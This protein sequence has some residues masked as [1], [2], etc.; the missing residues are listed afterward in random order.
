MS[1][2]QALLKKWSDDPDHFDFNGA[3]T[4]LWDYLTK[5]T[6]VLEK[7]TL[8]S[9][10]D[11]PLGRDVWQ[12]N[13]ER[14]L[15][16]TSHERQRCTTCQRVMTRR[17]PNGRCTGHNCRGVNVREKPDPN[18]YD[19]WLM[20]RPFVMVSAEEHTAQVPGEERNRIEQ[21]FKSKHGKTNCLV[22]TPTLEMGV[23]IGLLDMALMRNVP[24]KASNYWQRAGRAG[25]EERMAVIVTYCRRSN[26]DRYFFEDPLRLLGGAIEAP[27]FNL[28][29]PLMVAK[30]IRSAI[31]SELLL[32]AWD[33]SG[34]S[35]QARDVL[36]SL[37]PLFI[38]DT[39]STT[40]TVSGTF[41]RMLALSR[42]CWNSSSVRSPTGS[43]GY[44][45]ATGRKRQ[46]NWPHGRRL[47]G[48]SMRFRPRSK[49]SSGVSIDV[50]DGRG[51]SSRNCSPR[52][53]LG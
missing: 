36:K 1:A 35:E 31:L 40:T 18:D 34:P 24:P 9:S 7:V 48:R 2:V 5:E 27:A 37:F 4:A 38:R 49:T 41:R 16:D 11:R 20:G 26:H 44:S 23:N 28:R 12:V 25:R 32:R 22:A 21:D 30:H 51:R 8:R 10:R 43:L 14:V 13:A 15:V 53:R 45:P 42:H 19:V 3:A 39:C 50:W 47:R 6:R 52:C 29:N 33:G 46:A 17:A